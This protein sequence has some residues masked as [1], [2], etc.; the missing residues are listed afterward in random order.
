M[1]VQK[2]LSAKGARV[3]TAKPLTTLMEIAELLRTERIGVVVISADGE[4]VNGIL[5]ERDIIRAI[6]DKG[7]SALELTADQVMTREVVTCDRGDSVGTVMGRMNTGH[8]RHLPVIEDGKLCGM[9]SSTD[10]MGFR[11]EEVENEAE[12]LRSYISQ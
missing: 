6:A 4:A 2:M 10:V 8:F 9:I 3:V 1:T 11:L 12:H 5:S 7:A